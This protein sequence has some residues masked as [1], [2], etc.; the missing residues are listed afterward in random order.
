MKLVLI[1]SSYCKSSNDNN[2]IKVPLTC[3]MFDTE[4]FQ[5]EKTTEGN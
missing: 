1:F 3:M 4:I 2:E 5:G